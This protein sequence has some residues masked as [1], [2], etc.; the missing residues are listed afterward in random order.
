MLSQEI[1]GALAGGRFVVTVHALE[2]MIERGFLEIDIRNVGDTCSSILMQ[3]HGVWKVDGLDASGEKVSL[4]V[5]EEDDLLIVT[6][7]KRGEV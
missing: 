4:I 3:D 5:A 6:V 2:R 7:F 1:L